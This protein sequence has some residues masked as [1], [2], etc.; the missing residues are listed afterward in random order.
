MYSGAAACF[1]AAN[2]PSAKVSTVMLPAETSGARSLIA[3]ANLAT[4]GTAS[5]LHRN[6]RLE[7][8]APMYPLNGSGGYVEIN[9]HQVRLVIALYER[10]EAPISVRIDP[11]LFF[12]DHNGVP[13]IF[14]N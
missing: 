2:Q 12:Q 14:G 7:T 13:H 5:K 8:L 6:L 3:G 9:N 10:D 4:K 11:L 1:S